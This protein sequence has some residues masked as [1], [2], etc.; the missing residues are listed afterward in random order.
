MG[1][2]WLFA[3]NRPIYKLQQSKQAENIPITKSH[4]VRINL[5]LNLI[6]TKCP[7]FIGIPIKIN[8]CVRLFPGQ[9]PNNNRSARKSQFD[10]C[11]NLY[12]HVQIIHFFKISTFF[13][14]S[15]FSKYPFFKMSFFS[16]LRKKK[17]RSQQTC[18]YTLLC[19]IMY[20]LV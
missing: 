9:Y 1:D 17:F 20:I 11:S 6:Q 8:D 4:P 14:L 7:V 13:K 10:S 5:I 3:K 15:T 16:K 12:K 19:K 2:R 18:S